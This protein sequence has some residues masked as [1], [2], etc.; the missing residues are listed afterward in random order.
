MGELAWYAKRDFD[1]PNLQCLMGH[2][3]PEKWQAPGPREWLQKQYGKECIEKLAGPPALGGAFTPE[4]LQGPNL[5]T[6]PPGAVR[7]LAKAKA[8]K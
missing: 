3:L 2:R 5:L 8:K 4:I 6:A 7:E 1:S